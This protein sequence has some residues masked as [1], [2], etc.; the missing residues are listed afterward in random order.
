MQI[1]HFG[2]QNF[3]WTDDPEEMAPWVDRAGR[4]VNQKE[5]PEKEAFFLTPGWKKIGFS[6]SFSDS[7]AGIQDD[8]VLYPMV[9]EQ[10]QNAAPDSR[11]PT[12][13]ATLF[14]AAYIGPESTVCILTD[15][16]EKY[17]AL[18]Q[19]NPVLTGDVYNF[20]DLDFWNS[21]STLLFDETENWVISTSSNEFF[22]FACTPEIMDRFFDLAGGEKNLEYQYAILRN[23]N[24]GSTPGGGTRWLYSMVD[25][26]MPFDLIEG[27]GRLSNLD[28]TVVVPRDQ[29][30]ICD[31]FNIPPD[32][33]PAPPQYHESMYW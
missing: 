14:R 12:W 19:G 20:I 6:F 24:R 10:E 28:I 32:E 11:N 25:W 29:E 7:E 26:D 3:L 18:V 17:L 27:D 31:H 9:E 8:M 21:D 1:K 33:R 16:F 15:F 2:G 23:L 5:Y 4:L 22:F 30:K 13:L